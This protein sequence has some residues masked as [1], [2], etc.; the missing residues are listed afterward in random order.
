M[1]IRS[2][3][4]GI[5]LVLSIATLTAIPPSDATPPSDAK[6][7]AC[8]VLSGGGARG[9]AH[10]GVL[11]ALDEEGLA[12]DCIV[13]TSA[14]ALVGALYCSGYSGR[15]IEELFVNLNYHEL[16][17]DR[18]NRK[19]LDY[20]EKSR[21]QLQ[22][23][24]LTLYYENGD[25][26][27]PQGILNGQKILAELNLAF[28]RA[29]V[30]DIHDFNR[31]PIPFR[32]V[33][34]DLR[35]GGVHVFAGGNLVTAVRA[36]MAIPFVFAPVRLGDMVLVDGG[37]CN[38][39]PVDVARDLKYAR[40]VAVNVSGSVPP[41]KKQLKD[42]MQILDETFTLMRLDTDRRLMAMADLV[43]EP[44]VL[45]F[46]I[47]D[48][49]RVREI[50]AAGYTCARQHMA[51]LRAQLRPRSEIAHQPAET[52]TWKY[53][54][55]IRTVDVPGV[56]PALS[57]QVLR[58][59]DIHPGDRATDSRLAKSIEKIYALGFFKNVG[60]N[61]DYGPGTARL[62][63]IVE[64]R[65]KTSASVA[66][67]YDND[68]QFLAR[69]SLER[70][71]LFGSDGDLGVSLLLGQLK[72]YRATLR[73]PFPFF[74]PLLLSSQAYYTETPHDVHYDNTLLDTFRE[75][76]YG[77]SAGTLLNIGNVAGVFGSVHLE[78][79][80][81]ISLG[82]FDEKGVNR[83]NFLRLGAGIDTLNHW[84]YPTRGFR[85]EASVDRSTHLLG[86]D[87]TYTR[88][89]SRADVVVSPLT[90][91]VIRLFGTSDWGWNLP[92]YFISFA[93][94]NN[95]L[96]QTSAPLPGYDLDELYGKDLWT[97][98][99]EY[100]L[101]FPARYLGLVDASYLF[102]RYGVAGVRLPD[103]T[104][105]TVDLNTPYLFF[106]GAGVGY[107]LATRVG[108]VR[109]FIG[110]GEGGRWSWSLSVGPEF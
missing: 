99:V 10:I 12:P 108:P 56:T 27:L 69:L 9:L 107:A 7:P 42:F 106:H 50:I 105:D 92:P 80:N 82:L 17:D 57:Q 47:G 40:V 64:E 78:K 54:R 63:Y 24:S 23:E 2:A 76:H 45:D 94:G 20:G 26:R 83:D 62:D 8:L 29:G 103:V 60:F 61:L 96:R 86:G 44:P 37:V 53:T 39:I 38:N 110:A 84:L 65:P 33:A 35:A 67:H 13:G 85:L 55:P 88:I 71:D 14:G 32:A 93:G 28:A 36:S 77:V 11:K 1:R 25:L 3:L 97:G 89:R 95:T 18:P 30:Q 100:Q 48:F 102:F 4:I 51:E 52:G 31:L 74:R 58:K 21:P 109:F 34:T 81:T 19:L 15:E 73:S 101:R 46:S 90:N 104:A 98:N 22:F 6:P 75:R 72:D 87:F 49:T 68:Y 5:L 59:S 91:H 43:V 41:Q 79:V 66:L 16:L 70:R